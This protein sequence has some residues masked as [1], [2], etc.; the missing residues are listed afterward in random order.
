MRGG[1][2]LAYALIEPW[3]L[4]VREFEGFLP[5]LPEAAEGMRI[6]QISDLHA[7]AIQTRGFVRHVVETANAQRA[8]IVVLTGDIISRRSSYN[9]M[10]LGRYWAKPA[11]EYA[12]GAAAE[13]ANLRAPMGVFATPGNHDHW[14]QSFDSIAEILAPAGLKT[15]VNNSTLLPNGL[16]LIGLDDLRGGNPQYNIAFDGI[17]AAR[18]QLILSHNPR[19]SWLLA[20]RNALVLSGHTHGGQVRLPLGVRKLP[21]DHGTNFWSEGV[22]RFGHAQIYVSAGVGNVSLPLRFLVPPEIA[23]WTLHRK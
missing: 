22:Y 2:A 3:R 19:C 23:V 12:R 4:V 8:D 1:A 17:D 21:H 18:A 16:P 10:T 15:L 6:V 9:P 13:L 11:T 5:D 7:S 20:G 14:Q